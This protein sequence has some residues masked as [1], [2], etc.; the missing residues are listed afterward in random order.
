MSESHIGKPK[1]RGA[2]PFSIRETHPNWKGDKVG[3]NSL[4]DWIYRNLGKAKKCQDCGSI[5]KVE[6]SNISLE[7]KR[8]LNDW[9]KLCYSC[10]RK[11]DNKNGWGIIRIRFP[12]KGLS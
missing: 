2:Y 6:W 5:E 8:D 12:E 3:Y 11:Y 7:Y 9:Q 10:H 4:H 1:N